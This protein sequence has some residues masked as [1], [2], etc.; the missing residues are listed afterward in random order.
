MRENDSNRYRKLMLIF[1]MLIVVACNK[2]KTF[3]NNREHVKLGQELA[4]KFY[5]DIS[6]G[7]FD[8]ASN[9]F[10]E[11]VAKTDIITLLKQ[12]AELFGKL[13]AIKFVTAASH[14]TEKKRVLNGSMQLTFDATY[15]RLSTTEHFNISLKDNK[16]YIEGYDYKINIEKL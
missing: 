15:T 8:R 10:S 3:Q 16:I 5:K 1:S 4:G 12:N 9:Y 2:G 11:E 14:I 6:A 7:K 13:K